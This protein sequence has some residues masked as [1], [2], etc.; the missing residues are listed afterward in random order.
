M[1]LRFA[2]SVLFRLLDYCVADSRQSGK[3][4]EIICL[5]VLWH[6]ILLFPVCQTPYLFPV[7]C[8]LPATQLL[9]ALKV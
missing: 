8:Q 4:V 2:N 7:T 6:E 9:A 5:A 1:L 3:I